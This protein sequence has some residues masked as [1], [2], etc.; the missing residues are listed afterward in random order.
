MSAYFIVRA[1]VANPADRDA[2]DTWYRTE[3][4]PDALKAFKATSAMRG[5]SAVDPSV[6]VAFYRFETLDAAQAI[7]GS[8]VIKSL[9][10]EFDR[11]WGD[12][13]TRTRDVVSISDELKG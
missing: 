2:F 10:A 7:G 8:D 4:L 3:H 6:H 12:R 9:I 1:V 5:W 11:C 13:V